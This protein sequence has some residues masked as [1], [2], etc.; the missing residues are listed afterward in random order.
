MPVITAL[1]L[2]SQVGVFHMSKLPIKTK[3]SQAFFKQN[4]FNL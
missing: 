2:C 1:V 3:Y 4:C